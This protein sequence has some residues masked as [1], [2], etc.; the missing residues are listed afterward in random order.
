MLGERS[1]LGTQGLVQENYLNTHGWDFDLSSIQCSVSILQGAK[2][3]LSSPDA[4]KKLAALIPDAQL[5]LFDELGQYLLFSEW[6][7]IL[8][9]CAGQMPDEIKQDRVLGRFER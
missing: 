5:T 9:F 8:E 3:N 6:P 4:T 2:D 7:W 1:A